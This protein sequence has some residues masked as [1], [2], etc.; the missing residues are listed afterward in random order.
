V[1]LDQG[2]PFSFQIGTV[3][4]AIDRPVVYL[5]Q[6][7]WIELA[8]T[9]VGS[10]RISREKAAACRRL[11]DL[12]DRRKIILPISGAH[13]VVETAKTDGRQR[14][15]LARVML[16]L[17]SGWQ[18]RSPLWVRHQELICFFRTADRETSAQGL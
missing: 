10:T 6:N 16:S 15:D 17:S 5:D 18:M 13:L 3:A 14:A 8:R 9:Q 2:D 4:T 7:H 1:T 11:I 12:A